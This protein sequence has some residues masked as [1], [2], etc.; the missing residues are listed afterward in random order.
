[1]EINMISGTVE[2]VERNAKRK[3]DFKFA[4]VLGD[5]D[6][7]IRQNF[8]WHSTFVG[9]KNYDARV[10]AI[11]T[12]KK[13]LVRLLEFKIERRLGQSCIEGLK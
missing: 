5:S 9:R 8:K 4:L 11:E 2:L 6:Q 12:E 7:E 3:Q 1:M 13:G 10:K